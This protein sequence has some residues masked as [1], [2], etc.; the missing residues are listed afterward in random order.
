MNDLS[1]YE[2]ET[3]EPIDPVFDLDYVALTRDTE[4]GQGRIKLLGVMIVAFI[5]IACIVCCI[6]AYYYHK[7]AGELLE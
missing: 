2:A 7:S 1:P 3:L 5:L 6:V 4:V